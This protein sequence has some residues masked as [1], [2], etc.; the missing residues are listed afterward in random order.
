[1]P[2]ARIK[3]PTIPSKHS[4]MIDDHTGVATTKSSLA[5]TTSLALHSGT[6]SLALTS[7][8]NCLNFRPRRNRIRRP[9][10]TTSTAS[11]SSSSSHN[12]LLIIGAGDLG[13]LLGAQ[14]RALHPDAKIT[15][16][17]RT[18]RTHNRLHAAGLTPVLE[19]H[20]PAIVAPNVV[21]C[22]PPPKVSNYHDLVRAAT[23]RRATPTSRFVFVSSTAVHGPCP[24][25]T[26]RTPHGKT[27]RA[28]ILSDAE[29]LCR[30]L[31]SGAVMRFSGLF[32]LRRGSH[33]FWIAN[34]F[35]RVS[36]IRTVNLM[37]RFDA[38]AALV[39][40]LSLR[41]WPEPDDRAFLASS[42]VPVNAKEMCEAASAHPE[43][44]DQILPTIF[45]NR[46]DRRECD[47][48]WTRRT[49]DWKPQWESFAH[50]MRLDAERARM[51]LPSGRL[52]D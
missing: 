27:D 28:V 32:S 4:T 23:E 34:G 17:T 10:R 31:P 51:G 8:S 47:C 15:A 22:I 3:H 7:S 49:L 26:E 11:S 44:S 16:E 45:P 37:H 25:V 38:A 50:F 20:T 48:S 24:I 13:Y 19:S 36:E 33:A 6:G 46:V 35:E 5:F 29:K 39:A 42:G 9:F 2:K 41:E 18:S 30:S 12:D 1:M 14:W 40:L 43:F 21:F 52:I